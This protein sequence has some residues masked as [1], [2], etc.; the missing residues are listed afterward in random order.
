MKFSCFKM[1][2]EV[3]VATS[4]SNS[5]ST[6]AKTT[7]LEEKT[8]KLSSLWSEEKV[9]FNCRH[10]EYYSGVKLHTSFECRMVELSC[11]CKWS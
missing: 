9:L 7:F 1:A 10:K 4:S 11:A 2:D 6:K 3:V 8:E 5:H